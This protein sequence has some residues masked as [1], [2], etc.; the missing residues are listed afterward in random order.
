MYTIGINTTAVFYM[1]GTK[2]K[3]YYQEA[4]MHGY[5]AIG[6]NNPETM[7]TNNY[8]FEFQDPCPIHIELENMVCF[9]VVVVVKEKNAYFILF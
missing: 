2:F 8:C 6:D 9:F 7:R 5:I 3:Y 1:T 4:C